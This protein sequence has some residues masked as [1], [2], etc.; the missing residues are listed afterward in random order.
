MLVIVC[1]IFDWAS[2]RVLFDTFY[3]AARRG[4]RARRAARRRRGRHHTA[5][6]AAAGDS[7]WEEGTGR[8]MRVADALVVV[9]VTVV[10]PLTNLGAPPVI[11]RAPSS[12]LRSRK[13]LFL[14]Q[15]RQV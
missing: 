13:P 2:L 7:L 9:V 3:H 5:G 1:S 10:T 12:L 15:S 8:E 14:S 11:D 4:L 6:E